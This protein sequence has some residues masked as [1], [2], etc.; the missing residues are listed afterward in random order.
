M[1][2]NPI[3]N[4]NRKTE[5]KKGEVS[6]NTEAKPSFKGIESGIMSGIGKFFQLCDDIPMI[7]VAFTD[8]V[9]TNLPRTAVDLKQTGVPAATETAR[10]E[11]SGLIVNCLIPGA[12]VYGAAKLV[13]D[14]Y[15]KD[16]ITPKGTP[17]NLTRSWA[18]GEAIS[19]LVGVWSEYAGI[20]KDMRD[21]TKKEELNAFMQNSAGKKF[22]DKGFVKSALGKIEGLN[23]VDKWDKLSDHKNLIDEAANLLEPIM[24]S[25]SGRP[26]NP[27]QR[28]KFNRSRNKAFQNA[29]EVLINGQYSYKDQFGKKVTKVIDENGGFKASK[30]LKFN[31]KNIGS[32]LKNFLRDTADMGTMLSLSEEARLNPNRFAKQA[33]KLVNTKSLMGL[34]VVIPLAMSMQYINRAITRHKYK[35]S[36]APIYKDFENENRELTDNEKKQLKRTKP[37]AVGSIVGLAALSMGK[38]FPKSIKDAVNMLQFNT[39]FPTLNQCRVIATS[40]FASR[41]LAA[42]DPN[43]LRESTVRDLASF[44]GLYF[45]GDY[46]E[47]L[48]ATVI[49]KFSKKGKSGELQMFNKTK[50]PKE[51]KNVW[52]K[53]I[54]W[55]K[56]TNIKTFDEIPKEYKNYRSLAKLGGLG[57]SLMFLG[58]LLPMYNKHVTNKKEEKRKT[59]LEQQKKQ[60][61]IYD[62]KTIFPVKPADTAANT[63]AD[64][65]LGHKEYFSKLKDY[66]IDPAFSQIASKFIK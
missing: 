26:L 9:A 10:R 59:I 1:K 53:F 12:F 66:T 39:K 8:T 24:K 38:G 44:A 14:G 18:D 56:D 30:T 40:T 62:P 4:T 55:V 54:G 60:N 51:Y 45:L 17:L 31:G 34:A 36:G 20:T 13:N 42:E 65:A 28:F 33:T 46:A 50:N 37:L 25:D 15:M 35:K 16:Y 58:V 5:Y 41:M 2:I 64:S 29:Y 22:T 63:G 47:K 27:I 49:Q 6:R 19:N 7:G 32:D 11:F 48:A 3:Q 52:Q 21:I 23:G 61:N 57:F 43:E